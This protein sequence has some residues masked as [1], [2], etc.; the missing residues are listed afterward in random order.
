[1]R[2]A[3]D[4]YQNIGTINTESMV[5]VRLGRRNL[6]QIE[7]S[8]MKNIRV[9]D[10]FVLNGRTVRLVKSHLLTAQVVAADS[11][12]PTVSRWYASIVPLASGL[13]AVVVHL[14][15]A[16]AAYLHLTTPSRCPLSSVVPE[17]RCVSP[18]NSP[19]GSPPTSPGLFPSLHLL[20][21]THNL[22]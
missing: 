2:V 6:G 9:G 22:S 8:F 17:V 12:L 11:S 13:A 21:S 3:R 5:Q 18:I 15:T 14:R 10:V 7:E 16:L 1:P 19:P 4:F 20:P